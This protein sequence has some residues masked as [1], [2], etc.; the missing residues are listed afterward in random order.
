[1]DG[2]AEDPLQDWFI[3]VLCRCICGFICGCQRS[4]DIS[5]VV[6][7][8]YTVLWNNRLCY[9]LV[10]HFNSVYHSY[11]QKLWTLLYLTQVLPWNILGPCGQLCFG[12]LPVLNPAACPDQCQWRNN[13]FRTSEGLYWYL[14]SACPQY[15]HNTVDWLVQFILLHLRC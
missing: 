2:L 6:H 14:Y 5:G 1:M 12:K 4:I 8:E 13:L 7:V 3:I 9:C 15:A 11:I 10:L